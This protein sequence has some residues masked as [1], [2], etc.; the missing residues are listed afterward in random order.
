VTNGSGRRDQR[1]YQRTATELPVTVRA[2]G[3]KVEGGIRLD[4]T[5]VSEGGAFV[6]S[7][8]LFE[9]GELL[10]LEIAL[11]T[12][13]IVKA[14]GRVVR[15]ARSRS[16]GAVPGMGIEFTRLSMNDRRA[17]ADSLAA[18]KPAAPGKV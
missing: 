11:G 12:G 16:E 5:D 6:R 13:S 18:A 1:K 17:I 8:L 3:S 10:E 2:A 9:I 7:D 4:T 14:M 15:V